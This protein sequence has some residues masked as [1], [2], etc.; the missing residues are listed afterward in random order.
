MLRTL[1]HYHCGD[2]GVEILLQMPDDSRIRVGCL[3]AVT[4]SGR[5]VSPPIPITLVE[6]YRLNDRVDGAHLHLCIPNAQCIPE[7]RKRGSGAGPLDC[8]EFDHRRGIHPLSVVPRVDVTL[9]TPWCRV[10]WIISTRYLGLQRVS[11]YCP[12]HCHQSSLCKPKLFH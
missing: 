8:G 3:S 9:L 1:Y 2:A 11:G 6:Q 5:G 7:V 12:E 10:A 4:V